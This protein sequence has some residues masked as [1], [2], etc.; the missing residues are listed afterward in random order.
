MSAG[1]EH[2]VF[3]TLERLAEAAA[4]AVE[5]ELA[6]ALERSESASLVLAGGST[7]RVLYRLLAGAERRG[8][9]AWQQVDLYFGDERCVAPIDVASNYRMAH[10]TLIGP[11]GLASERV[12]RIRGE[13][14]P[15]PAADDYEARL[16]ERLG[17]RPR[18]DVVLLGMGGDGHT[19]SLF[20]GTAALDEDERL[21]VA[22]RAPVE[23]RERVTLTF[24]A[25]NAARRVLFLVAGSEKAPAVRR[26]AAGD[27]DAPAVRIRP[28][29]GRCT[30]YFDRAAA[31][32]IA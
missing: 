16:R 7:P 21:A 17:A 9:I 31:A 8:R 14:G 19:A 29:D 13:L 23:P 18:F 3:P 4:E 26:A 10:E 15:E 6:R 5:G 2:E 28:E 25:L 22:S 24:P 20:P 11:L 1:F 30:W 12:H 32:A 27:E